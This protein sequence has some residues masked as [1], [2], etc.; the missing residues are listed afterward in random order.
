MDGEIGSALNRAD[1]Y[2]GTDLTTDM[3]TNAAERRR[4]NDEYWS[5]VWPKREQLTSAV[6]DILLGHLDLVEG[7]RV[8]DVGS[9]GGTTTIAAGRLVGPRGSAVGADISAPLVEFARRRATDQRAVNV[10]FLVADV[11]HD[12][13]PGGPFDVALSRG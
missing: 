8:L 5:S 12:V 2:E 10:T 9:G 4:W 1:D 6:T 7:E 11:Q 13:I 3:E